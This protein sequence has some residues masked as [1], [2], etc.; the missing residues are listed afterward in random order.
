MAQRKPSKPSGSETPDMAQAAARLAQYAAGVL[1]QPESRSHSADLEL[2]PPERAL[3]IGL[4]ALGE[5]L[6]GRL[7]LPPGAPE[8]TRFTLADLSRMCLALSEAMVDAE[9]LEAVRMLS[10]AERVL[11]RLNHV[12]GK[13][14]K[15]ESAGQFVPKAKKVARK[16]LAAKSTGTAY[17]L[18]VT[19]KDVRPPIWRRVLVPDRALAAFHEVIQ[20][21]MGWENYHLY[22]FE[23]GGVGYTDPRGTGEL[24]MESAGRAKLSDVIPKE[25]FKFGYT[26]DFGDHW[27]H[28]VLVEKVLPPGEGQGYPVC[29]DGKRACPPEDVG[30][31]W[32]Y[33]GF[34]EV[35]SDPEHERH[36]EMLEWSGGEF[37]PEVFD[38]DAVNKEL[39]RLR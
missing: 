5:V 39:R 30:G 25:K 10:V 28:E 32:G 16:P 20:V 36:E 31:P 26:Y 7:E 22:S 3:L 1:A 37:D 4:P 34:L 13:L 17:Q 23:V 6:K 18:R 8:P 38:L 9:G 35:I 19:L 11:G 21:A 14:A 12:V 15:A 27:E 24:D 33:A 29:V 2:D